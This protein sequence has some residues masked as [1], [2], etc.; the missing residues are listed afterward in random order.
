MTFDELL[1]QVRE[2]LPREGRV[3]YR[4]PKRRFGLDDGDL[5][6]LKAET[7]WL[8][9]SRGHHHEWR[10]HDGRSVTNVRPTHP[11]ESGQD[12]MPAMQSFVEGSVYVNNLGEE[13]DERVRA[14]YGPNDE[15]LVAV[16]Q[17]YD[18]TNV[19]RLNQNVTPAGGERQH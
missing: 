10:R 17:T 18:P 1:T 15:R 16:K 14:A 5:E 8:N 12:V 11:F 13:G 4:A 19:F 6:A 2:L 7:G 9:V 3:S